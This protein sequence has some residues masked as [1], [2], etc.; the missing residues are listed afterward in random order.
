MSEAP[1]PLPTWA[2]VSV[3]VS[4]VIVLLGILSLAAIGARLMLS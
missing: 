3:I 4:F 2:S 1:E